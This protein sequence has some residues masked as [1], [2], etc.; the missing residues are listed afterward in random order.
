[1]PEIINKVFA[2]RDAPDGER[3]YSPVSMLRIYQTNAIYALIKTDRLMRITENEVLADKD[4]EPFTE[5]YVFDRLFDAIFA[6]TQKGK[7]LDMF[8]R[9]TQK[10]T[11]M[12]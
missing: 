4:S 1:M 2:V 6:N 7:S 5:Q 3:Y 11:S 10:T 9:I 8:D 12:F